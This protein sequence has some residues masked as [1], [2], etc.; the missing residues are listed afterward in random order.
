MKYLIQFMVNSFIRPSDLRV[1]KNEHVQVKTNPK[2]KNPRYN[3]YL[4]LTHPATKTTDQEIVTMA[5]CEP[6]YKKQ[7]ALQ[8]KVAFGSKNDYVFF[9]NYLN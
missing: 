6:V 2:E 9:Q 3:K 7:L 4:L 1:L 8:K 5:A